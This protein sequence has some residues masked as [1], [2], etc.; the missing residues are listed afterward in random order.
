MAEDKDELA[1]VNMDVDVL[2]C[3]VLIV[4]GLLGFLYMFKIDHSGFSCRGVALLL[5]L[6]SYI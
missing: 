4:V 6:Q 1:L 2:Q 5:W 3:D